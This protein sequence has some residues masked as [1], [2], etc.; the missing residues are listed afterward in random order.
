[1]GIGKTYSM[2]QPNDARLYLLFYWLNHPKF[3]EGSSEALLGINFL[4]VIV[5]GKIKFYKEGKCFQIKKFLFEF[6]K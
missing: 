3:F 6:K 2:K 5:G 4:L 1:M